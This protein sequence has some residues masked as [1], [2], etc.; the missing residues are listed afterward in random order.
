MDE[1][2]VGHRAAW[3]RREV[4]RARLSFTICEMKMGIAWPQRITESLLHECP[5]SQYCRTGPVHTQTLLLSV[6]QRDPCLD[7]GLVDAPGVEVGEPGT[8]PSLGRAGTLARAGSSRVY[9]STPRRNTASCN[10]SSW[11][12][13]STGVRFMGEK[14]SAGTPTCRAARRSHEEKGQHPG[15]PPAHPLQTA[16]R[17][18]V[19]AISGSGEDLWLQSELPVERGAW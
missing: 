8:Q 3:G 9:M 16:H 14:P 13:S 12:C 15:P 17:T 4:P 19:A 7:T 10:R 1:C 6:G 2:A 5:F 11:S 18:E